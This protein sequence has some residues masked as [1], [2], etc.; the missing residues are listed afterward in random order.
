M[1]LFILFIVNFSY[2]QS[3]VFPLVVDVNNSLVRG[4]QASNI[5][6]FKLAPPTTM[7]VEVAPSDALDIFPVEGGLSGS[8]MTT[9]YWDCCKPACSWAGNTAYDTP[10][11]SCEADGVTT[12]D[13]NEQSGCAA[14]GTSYACSDQQTYVVNDSLAIGYVAASFVGGADVSMCC[15]CLLLTFDGELEGKQLLAQITNTGTDLENNHFDIAIPGG[16][17][18]YFNI[19]CSTQWG[20][21]EDGWGERYGGVTSA[22]GCK[23]LPADLQH[24]CYWRF[25]WMRGVPNPNVTFV[26]VECPVQLLAIS[27]CGY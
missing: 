17:V 3:Q 21:P 7:K 27:G 11:R 22:E 4:P 8:G 26:Q 2:P 5:T 18:G 13:A 6:P 12:S 23:D 9:R 10:I 15:E 20:A 24:G 19:G 14:N 16:G 1:K 25:D